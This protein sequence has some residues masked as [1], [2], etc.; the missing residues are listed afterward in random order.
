MCG[1]AGIIR[2]D[3]A[4][5]EAGVIAAMT[6]AV[7]HRG[8]DGAGIL[9]EGPIGLGHRRL[10]IID[11]SDGGK[12]PMSY[13]DSGLTI[14]YNGEIY[15]YLELRRE[16]E[17]EG[18]RFVSDSD[19]EVIL[20][21]YAA[22]GRS[23]VLRF[24]G[25]WAFA[26]LDR[27]RNLLFCSRDRFGVKPFYY[28]DLPGRFVFGSEIR[29]ILPFLGSVRANRRVLEAFIVTDGTDL[30]E[31]TFFADVTKLPGGHSLVYDLAAHRFTVERYYEI[32]PREDIARLGQGEA[33]EAFGALLDDAVRLRLRSDVKVGTCLSGG[34]DS[35]S[36]ATL[37]AEAYRANGG[38]RFAAITAVSEQESNSEAEFAEAVVKASDLGWHPVRPTYEDFVATLDA[39]VRAQEE[40]YGG[41]SITMQYFV[42]KTARE[43]GITVLLDGQGGDETLLG[44][45][46]YYAAHI[47]EVF[48][49]HGLAATLRAL[50]RTGANNAKMSATNTAKYLVG[51]MVAPARYAFYR[52]RHSYLA[53]APAM[54]PHL[55]A[56]A[57]ACHDPFRLQ[58]LEIR[59]T[60]L[61]V[62]LRYEDKNS[63]AHGIEARLP[64]L[65]YRLLETSLSLPGEYKIHDGWTKWILRKHMDGR[66][67]DAIVWRKN[68]FG[69]EAPED[70][71]LKRHHGVMEQAVLASPI[72][73]EIA[74]RG[75]LAQHY[76]TLDKRSRWRLYSVALWEKAF[77]VA[78]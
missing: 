12:Q 51:G 34:L 6:D 8:P 61:P 15:N 47:A 50:R 38:G 28:A 2:K 43:N 10:S 40:P 73:G 23:C 4:P 1:I 39:V 71:W 70:V 20:A 37:A 54:P 7:A 42:M 45:E 69:F 9:V 18:F 25:M 66:M 58:E 72:I 68:K 65:D 67:P 59:S 11:L 46:K 49:K 52:W 77:G 74:D 56:F 36:V 3:G 31:A 19:T 5:V 21:A 60:N 13:S 26:L 35:S 33:A 24:N 48:R 22:W 75:R 14:T 78:A 76:R 32:R 29:Q 16:L 55:A 53:E 64:F 41:P 17:A 30:D 44:Y 57:R 27:R 62:L 63:M